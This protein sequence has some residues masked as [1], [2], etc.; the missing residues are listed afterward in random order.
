MITLKKKTGINLTVVHLIHF[1][2]SL[3]RKEGQFEPVA[4]NTSMEGKLTH[5]IEKSSQ[6]RGNMVSHVTLK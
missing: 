3:N 6:E 4:R 2:F 1:N 5:F